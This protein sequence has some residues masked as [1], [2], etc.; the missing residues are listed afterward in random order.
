MFSFYQ[1]VWSVIAAAVIGV[2]FAVAFVFIDGPY[3]KWFG[4]GLAAIVLAELL[5]FGSWIRVLGTRDHDLPFNMGYVYPW[6]LYFLFTLLMTV[7]AAGHMKNSYFLLIHAVGL[8]AAGIFVLVLSMGERSLREQD[9]NTAAG[10]AGKR[11]LKSAASEVRDLILA[12]FPADH[13]MRKLAEKV[14]DLGA[15]APLS[16][17]G[18][19]DEDDKLLDRLDALKTTLNTNCTPAEVTDA[20][21]SL[22]RAFSRRND[23]V[24][25]LR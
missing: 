11:Q 17:K 20:V 2:T 3:T 12:K 7:A 9:N 16:V 14:A 18:A 21:N 13:E 15:Y 10:P 19:E 25:D 1:K 23:L 5:A 4:V 22:A 24:K 8:V 6:W